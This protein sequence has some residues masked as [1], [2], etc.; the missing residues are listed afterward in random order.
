MTASEMFGVPIEGMDPAE[1][2]V[3]KTITHFGDTYAVIAFCLLLIIIPKARRTI[4]MPVSMA[5][6]L[7]LLLNIL[8]KAAFSKF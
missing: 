2:S 4:A 5:V 1:T 8:L 3:M 7:S 6:I